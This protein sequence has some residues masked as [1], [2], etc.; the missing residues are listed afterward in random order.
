[1][2]LRLLPFRQYDEQDVV[3]MFALDSSVALDNTT[4]DGEGSNGVFVKITDG[5]LNQDTISYGTDSY[6]GKT[7]YSHVNGSMYPTVALTISGARAGELPLGIT[8]NQTAKEDENGEKLLY[9]KTK[10]EELQAVLPGQSVP[11]A[12]KGIF[13]ISNSGFGGGL[14]QNFFTIGEGLTMHATLVGQITGA[15]LTN[16]G[17]G[18]SSVEAT[19]SYQGKAFGKVLA[20]GSRT[21]QGGITDQFAGDFVVVKI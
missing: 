10:K 9:N 4:Q 2:G 15:S 12:T 14:A 20:T 6:L 3:N 11:V 13:T 7:D 17:G 5:N 19:A 21:S 16:T 18:H 8:L 1:M